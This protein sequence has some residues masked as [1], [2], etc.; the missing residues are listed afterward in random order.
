MPKNW[1]GNLEYNTE[2]IYYPG[3]VEEIQNIVKKST[4][5]RAL[6]SRHSFNTIADSHENLISFDKFNA[7][8]QLDKVNY[9]L[10]VEAGV[11]YGEICKYLYD[12]GYA[13]H[14]LASL[15]HISVAGSI[16]TATHGSG[17]NNG[18]L[19]T[20]VS[21]IEFI[22]GEGGIVRLTK[23]DGQ[24]FFGAI[25]GLGALGLV[26]RVTLDLQP[27]F[28]MQQVV[29]RN[30]PMEQLE[31]NFIAIMSSGYSVS[32]FTDWK[33]KNINEVWV[34]DKIGAGNKLKIFSTEF[35][36]AKLATKNLHPI[37]D[38]P[39]RNCTDQ[40]GIPGPWYERLPHF[41]MGF[42][43]SAG[44][45]LQSEYFIPLEC[46]YEAI[47]AMEKLREKLA[48][49][50]FISEVRTIDADNFWMSPCYKKKC[51]AIH[52]TWKQ[53][54]AVGELL[55]LIEKALEPFMPLPH[56]GKLFTLQPP[57]LQSRLEKIS[58]FKQLMGRYDPKGKFRNEFINTFLFSEK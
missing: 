51:L 55:P 19:S 46:A 10:T 49:Y 14:N 57:V 23:S 30:L 25:V 44:K 3:S 13:L 8:V 5:L 36:G 29:Y 56:W 33:N 41:K 21:A 7:I 26:T 15:P 11:K 34:K 37:E 20:A 42:T 9:T 32:L 52:T 50:I 12:N 24:L 39:P 48:P 6:G 27:A 47:V 17:I 2:K 28:E 38:Q 35:Y 16:A 4:R 54:K 43:P 53:D 58:E 40:L 18:N 1:S 22:N 31:K 45:E